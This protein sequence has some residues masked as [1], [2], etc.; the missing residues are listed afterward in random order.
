MSIDRNEFIEALKAENIGTSVHFIPV[1]MFDYYKKKYGFEPE[2]Y[3][4]SK[5]VYEREISIPLYPKMGDEDVEDVIE[6]VKK[7]V[8]Y[9]RR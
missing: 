2:D 7:I 9:Y 6:A 8:E 5:R 3:P 4:V 1:H